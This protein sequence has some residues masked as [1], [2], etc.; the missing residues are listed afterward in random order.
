MH[1]LTRTHVQYNAML[2]TAECT[3]AHV[4]INWLAPVLGAG[5]VS[6]HKLQEERHGQRQVA[7]KTTLKAWDQQPVVTIIG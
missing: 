6:K 2:Q 5:V 4:F 1:P 7:V 3:A